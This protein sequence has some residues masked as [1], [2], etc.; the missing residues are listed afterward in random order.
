[1][2][3]ACLRFLTF[4]PLRPDFSFPRL[5]SCMASRTRFWDLRLYRFGM[6]PPGFVETAMAR[7]SVAIA[8]QGLRAPVVRVLGAARN[9]SEDFRQGG[10]G[11][12]ISYHILPERS[13]EDGLHIGRP[14][15]FCKILELAAGPRSGSAAS[16]ASEVRRMDEIPDAVKR[17]LATH[18]HSVEQLETLLLLKE[19]RD[20]EWSA[21]EVSGR[22]YTPPNSAAMRLADLER[23]GL[24]AEHPGSPP[25][26]RYSLSD[27]ALA[28]AVDRLAGIYK[29][30]RLTV[31]HLIYSKETEAIRLFLDAFRL[32]HE[33]GSEP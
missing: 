10:K 3:I 33:G 29:T 27:P 24:A 17:F 18:I 31:I 7:A 5:N 16:S 20:K 22:L 26:Y 2:A 28:D 32:K 6:F 25:V 4:F 30:H 15:Y 13:M 11:T 14:L 1:M 9:A 8:L 21:D 12:L 23:R 19:N